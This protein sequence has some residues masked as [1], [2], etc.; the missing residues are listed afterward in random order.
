MTS[1]SLGGADLIFGGFGDH[2]ILGDAG[3]NRV[4]RGPGNN[5]LLGGIDGGTSNKEDPGPQPK[6]A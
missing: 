4:E 2:K 1:P 3:T 6:R 5:A